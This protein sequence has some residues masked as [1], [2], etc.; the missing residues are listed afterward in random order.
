MG[1]S[2]NQI[3]DTFAL[4]LPKGRAPT[5]PPLAI[6]CAAEHQAGRVLPALDALARPRAETMALDE[7]F[8]R[9]Q[10]CLVGVEPASMALLLCQT[11]RI[12][13]RPPGNRR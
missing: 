2:L 10:P 9:R 4:L 13:R 8:F 1:L 6:G 12:V 11:R 5:A 3:E 7:I